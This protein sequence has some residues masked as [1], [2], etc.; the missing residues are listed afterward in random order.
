MG[1]PLRG[2]TLR[3]GPYRF[4]LEQRPLIMGIINLSPDSFSDGGLVR[5]SASAWRRAVR[6]REAGAD[7]LDVG[8]ESTRPGARSVPAT[9]ERARLLPV[10]RRLSKLSIPVSVDTYKPEVARAALDAGAC[11]LNDVQ[12]LNNP[13][14]WRLAAEYN[15]P[16]IIMHMRGQP[17]TMQ[18]APRYTRV[19]EDVRRE[20]LDAARR[21]RGAGVKASRIIL[22][23]GLGFGKTAQ[24]NLL[25][26]RDLPRLVRAGYPVLVGPSRKS[27]LTAILGPQPPRE[28]TWGTA[29]AVALAVAGGARILRVHD[30]AEMRMVA[31]VAQAIARGRLPRRKEA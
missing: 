5:G 23:P 25:L 29:A 8:A 18:K 6:L 24:H 1:S 11:L 31:Q 16:L 9:V 28:R 27:F 2:R 30:V 22:D 21:A 17:R 3:C 10:L 20:L 13:G 15:V 14:M 4:N 26:L 7:I 12:G 19:S